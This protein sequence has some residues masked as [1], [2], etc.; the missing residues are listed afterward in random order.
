[1]T[2][3]SS[4]AST[5]SSPPAPPR[6]IFKSPAFWLIAILLIAAGGAG[7][8]ALHSTPSTAPPSSTS[9]TMLSGC[10]LDQT[11]T[12]IQ[13]LSIT[14]VTASSA[15]VWFHPV[16][17]H[18]GGPD[19]RQYDPLVQTGTTVISTAIPITILDQN[20]QSVSGTFAQ[21]QTYVVAN[22]DGNIFLVQGPLTAPT[23]L[24]AV[25]HP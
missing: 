21:L 25:Y 24:I 17:L 5:M 1:M 22:S 16:D 8:Y 11:K 23:S 18:C 6:G 19:D 3:E 13:I 4:Q 7:G 14:G 10:A 20:F 2:D 15:T 12:Y 9:T